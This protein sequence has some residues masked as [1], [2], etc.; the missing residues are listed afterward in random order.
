MIQITKERIKELYVIEKQSITE[1]AKI[2]QCNPSNIYTHLKRMGI[3][4]RKFSEYRKYTI[5]KDY[6]KIIDNEDKAYILGL[7]YADGYN[8][9]KRSQ[10]RLT[11]H[12]KDKDIL[13]KINKCLNHSK[14]LL[15]LKENYLDLTINS[16]D[17]S[18]DL[19]K[20]GCVQNKTFKIVFPFQCIS[21][22]L[23]RHFIRG[24]FDGDGCICFSG[25]YNDIQ[26]NLTGN[27]LFIEQIQDILVNVLGITKTKLSKR[28]NSVMMFYHGKNIC[29]IILD[30]LY[31]DNKIAINRKNNLY[32][33]LVSLQQ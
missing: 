25:K 10:I 2:A 28:K 23:T 7:L 22:D 11:L 9:V 33:K 24:Y 26:L 27:P 17:I 3:N 21:E 29:R 18:L 6:F 31:K 20:L 19:E 15:L 32:K 5:D 4:I 1:I 14:P 13:D 30:Y 16:K 8:Q 12:K